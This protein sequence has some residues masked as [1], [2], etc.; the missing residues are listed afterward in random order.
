MIK[1]TI[2]KLFST[3]ASGMYIILFAIAIAVATFVENDFGTSSAQKI[4][5]KAWWFELLLLLFGLANLYNMFKFQL[6]RQKKWATLAFHASMVIILLG[7]SVTRYFGYEGMMHIRQDSS[8]SYFL[9][10]D[11]YLNFEANQGGEKFVFDEPV[12]F[13]TLG[14]NKLEKEYILGGQKIK[15]AVTEFMPNPK[16]RMIDV[17]GGVPTLKVVIGGANGR[18]EYYIKQGTSGRIRGTLFNFGL[19]EQPNAFN[20]KI[21][22]G[23]LVTKSNRDYQ[24]TVMAT[25][26]KSRLAANEYHPLQLRSLY[27][28]GRQSFVFG[29]YSPNARVE[30]I[31]ESK[32]MTSTSMGGLRIKVSSGENSQE[33]LIFGAKGLEGRSKVFTMGKTQLAISYGSKKIQLPFA[34]HLREFILEKYP[35]TNSASSY[36]SELTLIDPRNN[37]NKEERIFMN[38]ILDYDGYRFFQSSFDQDELGTYLSV[39]HDFWGTWISYLGYAIL[40]IGMFLTFF[41]K[42][43]RFQ[44]LARNLNKLQD[45]R[46]IASILVLGLFFKFH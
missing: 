35:G 34:L 8:S 18:E 24:Q 15:V 36:A 23:Q 25:Q 45:F 1:K 7:A 38:N 12:L 19:P 31:S 11:T 16:E 2:N 6:I 22:N 9:S 27:S 39:N 4:I 13:A 42:S 37:L 32:K 28:N 26:T 14:N 5:F 30:M 43:S 10:A 40:T 33:Q 3:T 21:E 29:E 44:Q 17:E 41:T 46:Q 20:I